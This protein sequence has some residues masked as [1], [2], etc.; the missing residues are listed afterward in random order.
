MTLFTQ[1]K[2]FPRV[3]K[4]NKGKYS[5]TWEQRAADYANLSKSPLLIIA[6]LVTPIIHAEHH[7]THLDGLLSTAA[8]TDHPVASQYDQAAVIPLP[9]ELLWVSTD[10]LPLWACTPLRPV[11]DDKG[12]DGVEYWH[13]RYPSHRAEFGHKLNANTTAGR[14]REYR[15]PVH[16]HSVNTLAALVIG[17]PAETQ[18]LLKE[19]THIGKKGSQGFGRVA[20]WEVQDSNHCADDIV[21][22]R[23]VPVAYLGEQSRSRI[24]P[25]CPWTPPY[26]Y[27]PRWADCVDG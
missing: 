7:L 5:Y 12:L 20:H 15:T 25:N 6:R 4:F 26:W 8:I 18:R 1:L 2:G 3:A 27:A 16:T 19:I 9:L 22:L 23:R 13:K 17:N 10:G 21:A 14:W 24:Q 11:N